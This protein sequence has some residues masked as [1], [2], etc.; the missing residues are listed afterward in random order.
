[1]ETGRDREIGH[2]PEDPDLAAVRD[3]LD[4]NVEAFAA[5]VSR[6]QVRLLNLAWRFCRD[7]AMAEDMAQEAFIKAFRVIGTFRG[8]AAFSTWLTAVAMNVYRSFLRQRP[9]PAAILDIDTAETP[10]A[11]SRL[12]VEE[13]ASA[14]RRL[15][16]TLP[17]RYQEPLVL[18]YFQEM[19]IAETATVL[20]IPE[21]TLKARLHR[22][23]ELLKRRLASM[24][25]A[26]TVDSAPDSAQVTRARE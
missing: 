23:R 6:W 25:A 8:E 16:L 5:I 21:G 17:R 14:I 3:V 13:R 18:F 11:V 15:V 24:N 7:R 20:G 19:N 12:V 2:E 1:V 4:G 26:R 22:G 10:D 9:P